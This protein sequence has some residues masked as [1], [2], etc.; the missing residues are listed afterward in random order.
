MFQEQQLALGNRRDGCGPRNIGKQGNLAE[1]V[2]L[3]QTVD[4][5]MAGY[6]DFIVS[7]WLTEFVLVPLD[8]VVLGRKRVPIDGIFWKSVRAK[9]GQPRG[10]RKAAA[11]GA[12]GG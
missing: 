2:A 11:A 4:N 7:Q 5:A 12:E 8:L 6:R 10:A 3:T 9:T 1:I